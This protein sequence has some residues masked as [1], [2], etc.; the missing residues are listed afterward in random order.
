MKMIM[1]E[2]KYLVPGDVLFEE[3]NATTIITITENLYTHAIAM[4]PVGLTRKGG[5]SFDFIL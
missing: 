5:R 2:R 1:V 4:I 3:R